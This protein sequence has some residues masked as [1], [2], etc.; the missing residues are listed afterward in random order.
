MCFHLTSPSLEGR[1]LS[2]LVFFVVASYRL[3]IP[4]SSCPGKMPDSSV[5]LHC[6]SVSAVDVLFLSTRPPYVFGKRRRRVIRFTAGQVGRNIAYGTDSSSAT[7]QCPA[8]NISDRYGC[9][10]KPQ[11]PTSI[12]TLKAAYRHARHTDIRK[13]TAVVYKRRCV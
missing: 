8:V 5:V 1:D 6:L 12:T 11:A 2:L 13:S 10:R 9:K 7:V 4:I 3:S